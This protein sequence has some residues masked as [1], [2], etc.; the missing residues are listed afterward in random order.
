[1]LNGTCLYH[2]LVSGDEVGHIYL[3]ADLFLSLGHVH[4]AVDPGL[5]T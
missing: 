2:C 5:G 4:R 3:N 1:M